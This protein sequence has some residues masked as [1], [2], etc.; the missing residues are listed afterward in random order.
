MHLHFSGLA[1]DSA[2]S[3]VE[4]NGR[5][6]GF[7]IGAFIVLLERNALEKKGI[8]LEV[9]V[10]RCQ[11]PERRP[12]LF[13]VEREGTV[14]LQ[15]AENA[16]TEIDVVDQVASHAADAMLLVI[17]GKVAHHA[18]ED[19]RLSCGGMEVWR[20]FEVQG[21]CSCGCAGLGPQKCD[22]QHFEKIIDLL[23]IVIRFGDLLPLGFGVLQEF[24]YEIALPGL[25]KFQ[26]ILLEDPPNLA[27]LCVRY[28]LQD[29]LF[30]LVTLFEIG[31][32]GVVRLVCCAFGIDDLLNDL[33]RVLCTHEAG[34]ERE[35]SHPE[36]AC[37]SNRHVA[38][39]PIR[40]VTAF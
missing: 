33:L 39:R 37:S 29:M 13:L 7:E 25:G 4:G 31:P 23:T 38:A 9:N 34:R 22:G 26:A 3:L 36:K 2:G 8:P 19:T 40:R 30:R 15:F 20:W 24:S 1:H 18:A 10:D 6:L 27:L 11:L 17:G 14:L 32:V 28:P 21:G 35:C 12:N 16:S 5:R